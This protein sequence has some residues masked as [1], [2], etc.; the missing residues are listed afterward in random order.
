[1]TVRPVGEPPTAVWFLQL[2][3]TSG[4][5][6]LHMWYPVRTSALGAVTQSRA[7]YKLAIRR[8]TERTS[9]PTPT[10]PPVAEPRP[11]FDDS[12]TP[13]APSPATTFTDSGR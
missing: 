11:P 6:V 12:T 7:D 3:P 8:K 2:P 9:A 13:A 5:L 4:K 10:D 1:L